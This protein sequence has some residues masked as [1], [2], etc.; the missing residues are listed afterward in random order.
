MPLAELLPMV[1]PNCD[2]RNSGAK[3]TTKMKVTGLRKT[4]DPDSSTL[5]TLKDFF[6][7]GPR[8]LF[9]R[10]SISKRQPC[11][12]NILKEPQAERNCCRRWPIGWTQSSH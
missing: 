5:F 9:R 10:T 7:A 1:K 4:V 6:V 11:A 3:N 8:L 12:K 2:L